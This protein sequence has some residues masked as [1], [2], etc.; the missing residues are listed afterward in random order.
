M[1]KYLI[2]YKQTA[3]EDE[4]EEFEGELQGAIKEATRDHNHQNY[5]RRGVRIYEITA[6]V[7]EK[8]ED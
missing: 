3:G 7:F 2:I 1:P 6:P 8:L 5:G 4:A